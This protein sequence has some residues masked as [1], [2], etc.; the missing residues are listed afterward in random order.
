MDVT[1]RL[2]P[3][4]WRLLDDAREHLEPSQDLASFVACAVAQ[5]PRQLPRARKPQADSEVRMPAGVSVIAP[6][7]AAALEL[8]RGDVVRVEQVTGGQCVDLV[9]WSLADSRERFSASRTRA[10][11]GV[12]P[13]LGDLLWSGPPFERPLLLIVADSAPGHDLLFPACSPAEYAG[14]AC[15]AEPSCVGVQSATAAA[16]G[17]ETSDLPDPF[18]L[19]LR[20]SVDADGAL[21]WESTATVAGDHVELLALVPLL[22]VIN[23]CVDDVFGCSGLEPGPIAVAT[24]DASASERDRARPISAEPAAPIGGRAR[25]LVRVAALPSAPASAW[26]ELTVRLPGGAGDESPAAVRAAAVEFALAVLRDQVP[27][28]PDGG[29]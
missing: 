17:L 26:R 28:S 12:S 23:P 22:V 24:R 2:S 1:L 14:S 13:G 10:V 11:A 9:A 6:G 27:R 5:A 18:N 4:Q 8:G 25:P 3:R 16:W 20:S 7:A 15:E 19:W 29:R 21:G